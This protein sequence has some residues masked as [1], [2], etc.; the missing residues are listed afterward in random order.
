MNSWDINLKNGGEHVTN[1]LAMI[2]V[3]LE[4]FL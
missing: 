1:Q 4:L 3:G 2:V